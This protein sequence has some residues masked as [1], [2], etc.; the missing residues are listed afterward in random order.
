[1]ERDLARL[2]QPL[3]DAGW[4]FLPV[5]GASEGRIHVSAQ[6]LE[7]AGVRESLLQSRRY[8]DFTFEVRRAQG[9]PA[10]WLPLRIVRGKAE[11][12]ALACLRCRLARLDAC[13]R[14]RID[15]ARGR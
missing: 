2:E 12:R 15:R 7:G 11:N 6:H 14:W 10:F 9:A 3:L 4:R 13:L 8:G 5:Q 1:M